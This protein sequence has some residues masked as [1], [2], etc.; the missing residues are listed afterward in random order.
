MEEKK[1]IQFKKDELGIKE[2]IKNSLGKG[3]ISNV[4]TEYTPIGEKI[5][6]FT[7][8]PGIIIGRKGEKINALTEILRKRF[9]LENPHI[10]IQEI[11]KLEFDA[12]SIADEIAIALERYGSLR[13]KIIAY[14]NLQRII[15]AGALGVEIRLGGKLPGERARSWRFA[16]GYLKKTGETSNV[17]DRAKSLAKTPSGVVGVKVS[18]LSPDKKIHDRIEIDRSI[19]EKIKTN[20]KE[21]SEK[22]PLVKEK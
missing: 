20:K 21:E 2:F 7:N 18:I 16:Q 9:R 19:K 17:V 15:D 3:R 1:F 4:I 13:F 11:K 6:V 22:E 8:K 5:I 14:K 12:Q 10:E